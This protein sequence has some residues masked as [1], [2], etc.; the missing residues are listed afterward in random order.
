[1]II[2][3]YLLKPFKLKKKK[4]KV[5][6]N[7]VINSIRILHF[8]FVDAL[9][10]KAANSTIKLPPVGYNNYNLKTRAETL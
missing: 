6:D 7:S 3:V 4:A 1:M 2:R 9:S 10:K 5:F 8:Y